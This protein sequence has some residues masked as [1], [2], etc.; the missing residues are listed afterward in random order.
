MAKPL[1]SLHPTVLTRG[2]LAL[3]SD[4]CCPFKW[5]LQRARNQVGAADYEI[6][7]KMRAGGIGHCLP[8]CCSRKHGLSKGGLRS[9]P[10]PCTGVIQAEPNPLSKTRDMLYLSGSLCG[11]CLRKGLAV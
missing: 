4:W 3:Y 8:H 1:N 7:S 11:I 6:W 5:H 9:D 2:L 10:K